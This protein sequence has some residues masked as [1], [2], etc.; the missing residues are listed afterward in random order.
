MRKLAAVE[1]A[2][3]LFEEAKTWGTW[4]WLVEKRRARAVAD[5]AWEALEQ[6]EAKLRA[7]WPDERRQAYQQHRELSAEARKAHKARMDAEERFDEA[8]R[9]MSSD[10]ACQGAQ[11]AV[12]AWVMREQFIRRLE[13]FGREIKG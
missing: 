10:L 2:K 7:G 1:E 9:R 4:R 8:D 5:A 12:D 13:K 3:K 11:M 6:E